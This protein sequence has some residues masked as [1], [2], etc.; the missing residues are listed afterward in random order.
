MSVLSLSNSRGVVSVYWLLLEKKEE[1]VAELKLERDLK[2]CH[3]H[4]LCV[5]SD[6]HCWIPWMQRQMGPLPFGHEQS[7]GWNSQ[8]TLGRAHREVQ[9]AEP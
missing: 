9:S 7:R 3:R 8:S 2:A 4:L 5:G 6:G 1:H